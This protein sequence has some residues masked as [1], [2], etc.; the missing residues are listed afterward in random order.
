MYGDVVLEEMALALRILEARWPCP[1]PWVLSHWPWPW[2]ST[3]ASPWPLA[4]ALEYVLDVGLELSYFQPGS[5]FHFHRYLDFIRGHCVK[6]AL[7]SQEANV[8]VLQPAGKDLQSS[9]LGTGR[10]GVQPLWTFH[11]PTSCQ[12]GRED[13]RG[14]CVPKV[15]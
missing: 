3:S 13:A 9:H 11:A 5:H 6:L 8:R 2:T 4:L 1:W 7:R 15:Q 10:E 14:P 12:N